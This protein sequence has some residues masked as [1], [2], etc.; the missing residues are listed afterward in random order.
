MLN[1]SKSPHGEAFSEVIRENPNIL[2]LKSKPDVTANA[3][4]YLKDIDSL[5]VPGL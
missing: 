3:G 4:Q 5:D 1:L 2:Q